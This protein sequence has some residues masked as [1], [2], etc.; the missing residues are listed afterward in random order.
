MNHPAL[1]PDALA[2]A[3][4]IRRGRGSVH[5]NEAGMELMADLWAEALCKK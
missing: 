2:T 5:P 3:W 4:T 1:Y